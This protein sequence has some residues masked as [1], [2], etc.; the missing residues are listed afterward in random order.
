MNWIQ[1]VLPSEGLQ[2]KILQYLSV[3][4]Q[5]NKSC[6]QIDAELVRYDFYR[7][8][9]ERKDEMLGIGGEQK[10]LYFAL[11]S[12]DEIIASVQIF[13]GKQSISQPQD[14][15]INLRPD[16]EETVLSAIM[17]ALPHH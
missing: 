8:L 11:D 9:E 7:W 6:L 17:E 15:Q 1:L 10:I 2:E 13:P 5:Y 4:K 14:L 12:Q 3:Y 16:Q